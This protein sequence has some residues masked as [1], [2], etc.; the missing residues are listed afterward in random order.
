MK[1]TNSFYCLFIRFTF[2][3]KRYFNDKNLSTL[4]FIIKRA[5]RCFF[6]KK[7]KKSYSIIKKSFSRLNYLHSGESCFIRFI[8]F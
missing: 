4:P 5:R 7:R 2:E 3:N 8:H 6:I 1:L